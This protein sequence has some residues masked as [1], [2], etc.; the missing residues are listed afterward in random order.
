MSTKRTNTAQA[1]QTTTGPEP[2]TTA[3]VEANLD[4]GQDAGQGFET[5]KADDFA[6]PFLQLL[7][8]L[9]PQVKRSDGAYIEGAAEGMIF[10][11]VTRAVVDTEKEPLIVVPCAYR[12]TYVEWRV[13][14]K[15]GGF[16]AEYDI[17]PGDTVRDDK[18]RDIL[19]NGNQL[20]DTRTFYVLVVDADGA[21]T[22]AVITMTSTQIR[23][24]KQ[25]FMQQNMLRLNGPNGMYT[26][27]MFASKW[28]VTTVPESNEKGSWYGWKFEHAGFMTK[29]DAAL[30]AMA[31]EFHKS[32]KGGAVTVDM[33]RS[34]TATG[35]A[36]KAT[37]DADKATRHAKR[38][39]SETGEDLEDDV[40]F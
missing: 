32:V 9:S 35:D 33:S 12:H 39:D 16:V 3:I 24:A 15:G 31:R 4:F 25:W 30:Y 20:N 5:A 38:T 1:A 22:P 17:P 14:E 18:G 34:E 21:T 27:P 28:A 23:K 6:I 7:Q 37:G 36:D 26:P 2:K 19:P 11:T 13:R 40:P 29:E 10:N 8:G